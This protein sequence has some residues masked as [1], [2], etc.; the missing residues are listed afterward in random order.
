VKPR[1]RLE[2]VVRR[3][4]TARSPAQIEALRIPALE[5]AA[6]EILGVVGSNGS[7]KSTL[8]ETLAFLCRPEEG[9]ILLD[10]I[11]VWAQGKSLDARRRCPMLL[12]RT[13]LF[14]MSVLKNVMYGLRA[15]GM[16]R[17]P[18]HERAEHVLRMVQLDE[19]ANRTHRELSGGERQRVALARLLAL[20]P[21]VLLLD[22]PTA[23]VDDSNARLIESTIQHLHATTGMTVVLASHDLRQ[24][25]T[26]ADR[27][28]TMVNGQLVPGTLD[29]VFVGT[30]EVQ[31][32]GFAF[33]G[34][35]GLLLKVA[36]EVIDCEPSADAASLAGK[37]TRIA[38][39]PDRLDILPGHAG[40]DGEFAGT[41]ETVHRRKDGCRLIVRLQS[42]PSV[43]ATISLSDY[44]QLGLNI[45][46]RVFLRPAAKALRVM[47]K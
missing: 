27:I 46:H 40:G 15:G 22:E 28:V 25:Q 18:A 34:Q 29:N 32:G 5:I 1:Y 30:F 11:D 20:E 43:G 37:S 33:H 26:L 36:S 31:D 7:G 38:L 4:R 2:H 9:R 45:G 42:G 24:A 41:I 13:V 8:L 14:K 3:Y 19:L 16:P 10:G 21:D 6:G 44:T 23:H 12:Q 47:S 39:D 17:R 35:D